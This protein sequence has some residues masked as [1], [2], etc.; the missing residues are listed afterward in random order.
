[1]YHPSLKE[2]IKKAKEGILNPFL[3]MV[4]FVE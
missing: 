1:M 4:K 2:F 3:V